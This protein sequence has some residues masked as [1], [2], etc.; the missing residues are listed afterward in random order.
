MRQRG[1]SAAS[2]TTSRKGSVGGQGAG[3]RGGVVAAVVR[4]HQHGDA[5]VPRSCDAR[6][7]GEGAQAVRQPR[8]L[9]PGRD[10]DGRTQAGR[11]G[12]LRGH[13]RGRFVRGGMHGSR[14]KR[15]KRAAVPGADGCRRCRMR[16]Q[17]PQGRS[18][19]PRAPWGNAMKLLFFDDFRL[20]VLKGDTRGRRVRRGQGHPAHRAARPD[21]RA[22]RAL[23]RLS[24]R[25]RGGRRRR[26][27][28]CR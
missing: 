9:V 24:R 1:G 22:D 14:Q 26:A 28:A 19:P 21:Q 18:A 7:P 16:A 5:G 23:R 13:R 17:S 4:Q 8:R 27:R 11:A 25:A 20:G 3:D 2:R 6:V 10:G 15:A 12:A